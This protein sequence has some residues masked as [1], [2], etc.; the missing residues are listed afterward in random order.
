MRIS[1]LTRPSATMAEPVSSDP[2]LF[3]ATQSRLS[4][5]TSGIPTVPHQ[6]WPSV[7]ADLTGSPA[8]AMSEKQLLL[9]LFRLTRATATIRSLSSGVHELAQATNYRLGYTM[10]S[11]HELRWPLLLIIERNQPN[12][13]PL[14]K[15]ATSEPL[16]VIN[17]GLEGNLRYQSG[18]THRHFNPATP[19]TIT[20]VLHHL[21]RQACQ[22]HFL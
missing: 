17:A 2:R 14:F 5:S 15:S 12:G 21:Q 7:A 18:T 13:D 22:Q 8:T 16:A 6:L 3:A 9:R 11:T 20:Q 4:E 10:K 19:K 1:F